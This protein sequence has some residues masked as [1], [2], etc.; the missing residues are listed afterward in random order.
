[1]QSICVL[2]IDRS[3]VIMY[4]VLGNMKVHL[5][6]IHPFWMYRWRTNRRFIQRVWKFVCMFVWLCI[7]R[8]CV[9]CCSTQICVYLT[10][11][12]IVLHWNWHTTVNFSVNHLYHLHIIVITLWLSCI[13]LKYLCVVRW[14]GG[15][16]VGLNEK[17]FFEFGFCDRF[18]IKI[19]PTR[20]KID[21]LT[22]KKNYA[23]FSL[24]SKHNCEQ[25]DGVTAR[26][27]FIFLSLAI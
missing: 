25:C 4:H 20:K 6:K 13:P 22:K 5:F 19:H 7:N 12:F 8:E 27:L 1:M 23:T 9:E 3:I 21:K 16:L 14:L 10:K 15:W 2:L 24:R 17:Y 18:T 11:L 26:S